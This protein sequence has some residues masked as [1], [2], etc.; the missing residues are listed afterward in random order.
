MQENWVVWA[1]K[2]EEQLDAYKQ[3]IAEEEVAS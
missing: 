1:E 2:Y 3:L